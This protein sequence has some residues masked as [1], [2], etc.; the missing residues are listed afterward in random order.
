M[1]KYYIH[2]KQQ[3]ESYT[4]ELNSIED[5]RHWIINHLNISQKW[6]IKEHKEIIY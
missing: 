3:T 1:T 5:A 2:N 6:V 4:V